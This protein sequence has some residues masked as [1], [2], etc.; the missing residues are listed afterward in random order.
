MVFGQ[1]TRA[2]L[3]AHAKG[4]HLARLSYNAKRAH[5]TE[6][7]TVCMVTGIVSM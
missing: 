1:I 3:E 7:I 5:R 6:F 4:G 2:L